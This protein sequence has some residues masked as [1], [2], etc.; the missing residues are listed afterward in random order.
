MEM[1]ERLLFGNQLDVI[2]ARVPDQLANFIDEPGYYI[3]VAHSK[4]YVRRVWG[5][6]F[7]VV[8]IIPGMIATHD[9]AVL[10]KR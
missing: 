1:T 6:Y 9:L 10:R 4:D 5:E 8:D 2:A 3:N 7:E